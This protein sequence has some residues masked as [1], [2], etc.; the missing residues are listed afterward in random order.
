MRH[1]L[2]LRQD[3]TMW[4]ATVVLEEQTV[5]TMIKQHYTMVVL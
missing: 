1:V 4:Y 5:Q 3:I 2:R